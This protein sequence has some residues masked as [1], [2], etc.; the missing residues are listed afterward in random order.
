MIRRLIPPALAALA[1]ALLTAAPVGAAEI[2]PHEVVVKREGAAPEVERVRDVE[3]AIAALRR[4]DGV[5]YAAP[6]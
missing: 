5:E 3:K 2:V 6:N 4:S 1:A